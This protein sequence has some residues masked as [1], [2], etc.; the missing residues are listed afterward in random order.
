M[1]KKTIKFIVMITT[2]VSLG[3]A[4]AETDN[5]NLFSYLSK[6]RGLVGENS[7]P[8]V[9]FLEKNCKFGSADG[10]K[11]R[12]NYSEIYE[13]QLNDKSITVG[14]NIQKKTKTTE[15][16]SLLAPEELYQNIF[17]KIEEKNGRG[18]KID[19]SGGSYKINGWT[20]SLSSSKNVSLEIEIIK[21]DKKV[22][23]QAHVEGNE[24]P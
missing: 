22:L 10:G 6:P 13:C 19:E 20:I 7:K 12:G 14:V 17:K 11:L 2:T 23:L 4:M 16:F 21:K 9:L 15:Y 18:Y 5:G 1:I 3:A 24:G 8:L